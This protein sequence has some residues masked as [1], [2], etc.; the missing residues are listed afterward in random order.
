MCPIYSP[1][2]GSV[3]RCFRDAS[4]GL[5]AT[6]SPA[7][8]QVVVGFEVRRVPRPAVAH[9]SACP[10]AQAATPSAE[11]RGAASVVSNT[12]IAGVVVGAFS[13]SHAL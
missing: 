12:V 10:E 2:R 3:L 7:R 4:S 8:L 1:T 6:R 5:S 11:A 13:L 9:R